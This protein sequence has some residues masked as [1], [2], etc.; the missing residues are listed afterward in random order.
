[1]YYAVLLKISTRCYRA[2]GPD[3]GD[4]VDVDAASGGNFDR[5]FAAP[6]MYCSTQ[7]VR[8]PSS[9]TEEALL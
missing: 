3:T 6:F 1:M 7:I 9:L 4:L 8:R 2:R 5:R